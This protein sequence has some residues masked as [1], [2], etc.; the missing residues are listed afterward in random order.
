MS[1]TAKVKTFLFTNNNS[2]AQTSL[3]KR[4]VVGDVHRVAQATWW[5]RSQSVGRRGRGLS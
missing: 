2:S 4:W 3:A 1:L 5:V